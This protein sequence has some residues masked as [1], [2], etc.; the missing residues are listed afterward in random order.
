MSECLY[1]AIGSCGLLKVGRT[2]NTH[3]RKRSLRMIF[4]EKSDVLFKFKSCEKMHIA[5]EAEKELLEHMR[6]IA[7][8]H[9]GKEWFTG[10]SFDDAYSMALEITSRWNAPTHLARK[11]KRQ[12]KSSHVMQQW[13]IDAMAIRETELISEPVRK[14]I[15]FI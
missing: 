9:S 10:A 3:A 4:S 6:K 13:F 7:T 8:I 1:V 2:S 5:N 12:P 11:P 14:F 15:R